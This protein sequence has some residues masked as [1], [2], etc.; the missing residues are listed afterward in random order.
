MSIQARSILLSDEQ[1]VKVN[2]DAALLFGMTT[3][4]RS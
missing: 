4:R 1:E 3:K 2:P